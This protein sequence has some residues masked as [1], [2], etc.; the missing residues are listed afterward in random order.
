MSLEYA[1]EQL[2]RELRERFA[3]PEEQARHVA[4]WYQDEIA[5][6]EAAVKAAQEVWDSIPS[7]YDE[8]DPMVRRHVV[9]L[10]TLGAALQ[11][12]QERKG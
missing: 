4:Q 8:A 10:N 3:L 9:A 5:K 12:L 1:V 2:M 11:R 6:L 7:S